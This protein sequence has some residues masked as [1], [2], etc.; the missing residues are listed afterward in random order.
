[1]NVSD[2]K[3]TNMSRWLLEYVA[4]SDY[5]MEHCFPE[6]FDDLLKRFEQNDALFQAYYRFVM[7]L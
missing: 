4:S 5:G 2:A 6:D 1:M 7:T 3:L